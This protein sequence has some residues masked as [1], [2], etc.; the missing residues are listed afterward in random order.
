SMRLEKGFL[1][2]KSDILTEFDPFETGLDRF[3]RMNKPDFVGKVSLEARRS[4]GPQ[5][6]LVT[7]EVDSRDAPAHGGASVMLNEKVIGTVTSGDWGHRVG[8]NLAYA[9]VNPEFSEIG[10]A[11]QVDIIGN[12]TPAKVIP[13][14]PY[15]PDMIL[16][17]T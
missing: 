3:V 16:P 7:L 9:F 13:A 14:S 5:K 8:K 11:M 4:G 10:C 17:R 1:H 2:W 12:L 15:D 6:Q